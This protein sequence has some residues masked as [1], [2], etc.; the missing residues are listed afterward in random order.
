MLRKENKLLNKKS[1]NDFALSFYYDNF[2]RLQKL[3]A[4]LEKIP[5]AQVKKE[6]IIA[7]KSEQIKEVFC[8][9][10]FMYVNII[11]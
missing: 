8:S 11:V 7:E 5:S 1:N 9:A 4:K 10:K 6:K 2:F 3:A